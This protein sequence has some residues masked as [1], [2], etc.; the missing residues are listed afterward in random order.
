MAAGPANCDCSYHARGGL[1]SSGSAEADDDDVLQATVAKEAKDTWVS[2][3][4]VHN[5][6]PCIIVPVIEYL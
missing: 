4:G 6:F 3:K 5:F 2:F 1:G